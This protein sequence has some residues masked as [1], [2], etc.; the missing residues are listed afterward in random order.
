MTHHITLQL[1]VYH[2]SVCVCVCE[3]VVW[4][5]GMSEISVSN[6]LTSLRNTL[7]VYF[8]V[9]LCVCVCVCRSICVAG[10]Y[11]SVSV[12]LTTSRLDSKFGDQKSL[13]HTNTCVP[14]LVRTSTDFCVTVATL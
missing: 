11:M 10:G 4:G 14:V 1:S 13:F 3:K 2:V 12:A 6:L 7:M 8:G 9:F 5:V